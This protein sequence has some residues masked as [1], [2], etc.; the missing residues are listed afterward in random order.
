MVAD[1]AQADAVANRCVDERISRV[2]PDPLTDRYSSMKTR[3]VLRTC[4]V[5]M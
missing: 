1:P 2:V 4:H 3:I 5:A